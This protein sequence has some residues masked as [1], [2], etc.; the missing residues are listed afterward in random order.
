MWAVITL[1]FVYAFLLGVAAP[2]TPQKRVSSGI[3]SVQ[4]GNSVVTACATLQP[5]ASR[6]KVSVP[7]TIIASFLFNATARKLSDRAMASAS[8]CTAS[9]SRLFDGLDIY[10]VF[11]FLNILCWAYFLFGTI[12]TLR[13][14]T[15][16]NV[17]TVCVCVKLLLFP[18]VHIIN[19]TAICV[20]RN[21]S[22]R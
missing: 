13:S 7:R 15:P 10:A 21:P 17:R 3:Y 1:L 9:L 2:L 4:F 20:L 6:T 11:P 16:R 5:P 12:H 19:P 14:N 22:H 8:L 18:A